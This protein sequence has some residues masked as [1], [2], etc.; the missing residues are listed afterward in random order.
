MNLNVEGGCLCWLR[1]RHEDV[2][3]GEDKEGE[4]MLRYSGGSEFEDVSSYGGFGGESGAVFIV[5]FIISSNAYQWRESSEWYPDIE[6]DTPL[7]TLGMTKRKL[8]I[9]YFLLDNRGFPTFLG[10]LHHDVSSPIRIWDPS[11]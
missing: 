1:G 11:R 5:W 3:E 10:W 2:D 9:K 8:L 4:F 6:I 7:S